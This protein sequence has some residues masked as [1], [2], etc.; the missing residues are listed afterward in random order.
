MNIVSE[1]QKIKVNDVIFQLFPQ[2]HGAIKSLGIRVE[3]FVYSCDISSIPDNSEKYLYN[4]KVWVVDCVDYKSNTKH[5]GLERVFEWSKKY[6]P[7][8]IYLTNMS[9]N[10]DYHEIITKIPPHIIPLYDGFKI[11]L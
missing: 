9:H 8:K 11:K 2:I 10:I 6:G 3:E 7:E 1:F 4:T 5:A